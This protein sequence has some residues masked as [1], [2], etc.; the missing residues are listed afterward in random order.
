MHP[1]GTPKEQFD[2]FQKLAPAVRYLEQR[3]REHIQLSELAE[4][5]GLSSTHVHRLFRRLLRM[6][7][8]EYLLALRLQEARRLLITTDHP[9]SV[10]AVDTG[11]FDQ[12]HFAKRFRKVTG[13]TPIQYRKTFQ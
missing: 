7:P 8:T 2:R 9:L 11:F 12:S 13:M 5:C 6:S 10:I 3:F 1:I 4:F